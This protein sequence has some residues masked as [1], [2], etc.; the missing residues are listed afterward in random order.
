M[1]FSA[2]CPP[3]VVCRD[4]LLSY[5]GEGSSCDNVVGYKF[6]FGRDIIP[7]RPLLMV[8]RKLKHSLRFGIYAVIII[9]GVMIP[10]RTRCLT[11]KKVER[12]TNSELVARI[13]Y[14]IV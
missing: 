5:D 11:F 10:L 3:C 14:R 13:F 2:I 9:K 4:G 1:F 6:M 12:N 7:S 8:V